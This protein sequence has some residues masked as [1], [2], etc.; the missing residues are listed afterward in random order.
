MGVGLLA[1]AGGVLR[2]IGFIGGSHA[3]HGLSIV[4]I[5]ARLLL[6]A[7]PAEA[8]EGIRGVYAIGDALLSGR[9]ERREVRR[10][11]VDIGFGIRG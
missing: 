7:M 6:E 3:R 1:S 5:G 8:L 9:N 2:D 10:R 11:A 4:G